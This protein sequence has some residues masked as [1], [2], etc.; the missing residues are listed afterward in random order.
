MAIQEIGFNASNLYQI[1][2]TGPEAGK[3]NLIGATNVSDVDPLAGTAIDGLALV[4]SG[5]LFGT[6]SVTNELYEL[7]RVDGDATLIGP[8]GDRRPRRT[9][10]RHR[11]RVGSR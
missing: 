3:V 5:R 4:N 11:R 10:V 9:G 8:G 2:D 1:N 7:S 6:N